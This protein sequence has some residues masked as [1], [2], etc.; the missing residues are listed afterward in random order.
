MA[1]DAKE[2]PADLCVTFLSFLDHPQPFR[3]LQSGEQAI[4]IIPLFRFSSL[5]LLRYTSDLEL[6]YDYTPT[7][8]VLPPFVESC[9]SPALLS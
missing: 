1:V 8:R 3:P 6:E 9:C 2:K 7:S 5:T 4:R